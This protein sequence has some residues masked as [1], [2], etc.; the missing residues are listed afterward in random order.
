NWLETEDL[1]GFFV[2]QLVLCSQ[3]SGNPSCKELLGRVR[4]TTLGAYANQDAPFETLVGK[5]SRER[6]LSR[7]ALFQVMFTLQ[8]VMLQT[9]HSLP[10][11]T[12]SPVEMETSGSKFDITLQVFELDEQVRGA[13][14]YSTDLF[15]R[16]T[17]LQ[18]VAHLQRSLEGMISN[19]C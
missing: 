12:I 17:I 2:N 1:I 16:N 11:L 15:N 9:A 3:L 10:E 18:I 7:N 14:E 19:P 8:N 6:D 4:E 13:L 5:F